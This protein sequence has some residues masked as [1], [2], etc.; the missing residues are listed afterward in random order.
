LWGR[1][2][3]DELAVSIYFEYVLR[4][5]IGDSKL[6]TLCV[7]C[8]PMGSWVGGLFTTF[9]MKYVAMKGVN[10]SIIAPGN[11]VPE[12]VQ[13][14]QACVDK[15]SWGQCVLMGYPPFLKAVLDDEFF[16]TFQASKGKSFWES[17]FGETKMVFAGEVFSEEWRT[18]MAQKV[19]IPTKEIPFSFCSMY[20]TA[21]AAV[22]AVETPLSIEIRRFLASKP[23]LAAKIFGKSRLPTLCQYSPNVKFLECIKSDTEAADSLVISSIPF[24][25]A[26]KKTLEPRTLPT[27]RYEIGDDGGIMDFERLLSAITEHGF[28]SSISRVS[29]FPFVWVFGRK[30]WTLSLYGA[31]VYVENIMAA[32]ESN[33]FSDSI[34]GK[35]VIYLH[36]DEKNERLGIVVELSKSSTQSCSL[37]EQALLTK[38]LA[39]HFKEEICRLN[40]EYKNYIPVEMQVPVVTL[41]PF[42]D[43]Q[44]FPVGVKHKYV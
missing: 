26:Q 37:E 12:I 24:G 31:N 10:I 20:G 41:K 15:A 25:F 4:E 43:P 2:L 23:D 38:N 21:D 33:T 34:T 39:L 29:K 44:Y 27:F 3:S 14:L 28:K 11:K 5:F 18:S 8:F 36:N 22:I 35:F 42:G 19:G 6:P 9:G 40:Y 32:V 16:Q 17:Y 30:F 1:S 7:I 13:S